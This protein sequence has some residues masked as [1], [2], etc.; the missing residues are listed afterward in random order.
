MKQGR[1]H[2]S[3]LTSAVCTTFV[4]IM[5][6]ITLTRYNPKSDTSDIILS[7]ILV[8]LL[9]NTIGLW[10]RGTKKY[11]DFAIEEKIKQKE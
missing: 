10:I 5:I 6:M 9:I 4:A 7:V 8:A 3:D 1:S 2:K 11:I